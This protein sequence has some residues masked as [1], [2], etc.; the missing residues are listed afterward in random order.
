MTEWINEVKETWEFPGEKLLVAACL[1]N[2]SLR[3]VF[4]SVERFSLIVSG[5]F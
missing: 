5:S 4:E 2:P 1:P 3:R